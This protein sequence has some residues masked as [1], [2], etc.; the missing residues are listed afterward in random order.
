MELLPSSWADIAHEELVGVL[1]GWFRVSNLS[2]TGLAFP[3]KG[4]HC[5]VEVRA[6][7]DGTIASIR[8]GPAFNQLKWDEIV[9]D[10]IGTLQRGTPAVGR[11]IVLASRRVSGCWRSD[12]C[13]VQILPAPGAY[14]EPLAESALRP[15]M[16]EF[17]VVESANGFV[18]NSRRFRQV[19]RY[20]RLLNILLRPIVRPADSVS[21]RHTWVYLPGGTESAWVQEGFNGGGYAG[22]ATQLS[23]SGPDRLEVIDASTYYSDKCSFGQGLAVPSNLGDSLVHYS[24]LSAVETRMFDRAAYWVELSD[25]MWEL[26]KSSSFISLVTAIEC[27]LPRGGIHGT[28]C[29][30]CGERFDHETPGPTRQFKHFVEKYGAGDVSNQARSD[31]YNLRSGIV[32]GDRLLQF[33]MPVSWM[34]GDA[35]QYS[36]LDLHHSLSQALKTVMRNWLYFRVEVVADAR[37]E[38]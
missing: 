29:E 22:Y 23:E 2:G 10:V 17:P 28:T 5:F 11:A 8:P 36:Q 21:P 9:L 27:F 16:L 37:T 30:R 34:G 19:L 4:A 24:G 13:G 14:P 3:Y 38:L 32:H 18:S 1:L 7:E 25:V 20:S 33:D 12:R 26:S 15:F 31:L 35:R 6:A